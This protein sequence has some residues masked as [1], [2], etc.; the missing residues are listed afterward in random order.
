MVPEY[1]RS[2]ALY[3]S[4]VKWQGNPVDLIRVLRLL[5]DHDNKVAKANSEVKVD[6]VSKAA[7]KQ[8]CNK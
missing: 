4:K 5:Y 3:F 6:K 1:A 7:S 8:H 2:E